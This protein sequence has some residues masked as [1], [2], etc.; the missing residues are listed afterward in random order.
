MRQTRFQPGDV[1]EVE[2]QNG[3]WAYIQLVGLTYVTKER[4]RPKASMVRVLPGVYASRLPDEKIE[5]LVARDAAFFSQVPLSGMLAYGQV[6]GRWSLPAHESV[7]PDTRYWMQRSDENPHGWKV[8]T[9]GRQPMTEREY[10]KVHPDVDQ[11]TLPF[12]YIPTPA[13]LRWLIQVGWTP[14]EARSQTDDWW[15]DQNHP[16]LP[17][18][19]I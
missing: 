12:E 11:T 18:T 13:R 4:S 16:S 14:R 7:V 2:L 19:E 5:V 3:N 1:V 8:V 17:P 10:S 9:S 6:R 15:S